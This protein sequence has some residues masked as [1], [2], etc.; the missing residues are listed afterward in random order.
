MKAAR[1]ARFKPWPGGE[2]LH[3]HYLYFVI[4][5]SSLVLVT[6][7]SICEQSCGM[8]AQWFSTDTPSRKAAGDTESRLGKTSC[9]ICFFLVEDWKVF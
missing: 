2:L 4:E 7:N 6:L 5:M 1:G 9:G 8:V 3:Q